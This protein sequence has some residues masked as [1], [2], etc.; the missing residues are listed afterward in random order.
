MTLSARDLSCE[1]AEVIRPEERDGSNE[2]KVLINTLVSSEMI[3]R[4][5]DCSELPLIVRRS[6]LGRIYRQ[7]VREHIALERL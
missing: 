6:I 4:I 1:A 3:A 5:A 7:D 2:T